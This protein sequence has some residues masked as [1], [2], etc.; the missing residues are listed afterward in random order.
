MGLTVVHSRAKD[1]YC[2][3]VEDHHTGRILPSSMTEELHSRTRVQIYLI[4]QA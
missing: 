3:F 1:Q 2:E 4:A